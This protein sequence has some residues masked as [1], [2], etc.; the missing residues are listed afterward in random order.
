MHKNEAKIDK[1]TLQ[2]LISS[3]FPNW[4]TETIKQI[5][6]SGTDNIVFKLGK[7]KCIRL[8]RTLQAA[9]QLKKRTRMAT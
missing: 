5:S 8:P 3:Q 9:T 6:F 7:D 1:I 2:N 4:K